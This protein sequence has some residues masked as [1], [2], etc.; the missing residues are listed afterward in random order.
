MLP[1][2]GILSSSVASIMEKSEAQ[3]AFSA[4]DSSAFVDRVSTGPLPSSLVAGMSD[5]AGL[6]DNRLRAL[7]RSS[8]LSSI[9][10]AKMLGLP[11]WRKQRRKCWEELAV[12]G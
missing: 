4:W 12:A 2:I 9:E 6:A 1:G 7:D 11:I 10:V 3:S 5:E 8:S